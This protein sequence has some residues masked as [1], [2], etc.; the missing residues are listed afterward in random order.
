MQISDLHADLNEMF[1]LWRQIVM[2]LWR[3]YAPQLHMPVLTTRL[4]AALPVSLALSGAQT[5]LLVP[6]HAPTLRRHV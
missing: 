3:V 6:I 4:L 2:S 5:H 1:V